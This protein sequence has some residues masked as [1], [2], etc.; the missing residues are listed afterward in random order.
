[1]KKFVF[2]IDGSTAPFN[3]QFIFNQVKNKFPEAKKEEKKVGTF[4]WDCYIS[5]NRTNEK[6][7]FEMIR[8]FASQTMHAN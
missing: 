1:M 2:R 5:V 4:A 6:Q 3:I 7:A 8:G